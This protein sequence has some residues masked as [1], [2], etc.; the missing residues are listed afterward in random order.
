VTQGMLKP[1]FFAVVI[2]L[3]GCYCGLKTRGGTEGVG[4]ATTRAMVVA[5]VWILLLDVLITRL[6]IGI[7]FA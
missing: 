6:L 4:R 3:V 2:A 1:F 7:G 5:S